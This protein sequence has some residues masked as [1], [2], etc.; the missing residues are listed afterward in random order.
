P[1][2]WGYRLVDRALGSHLAGCGLP[3]IAL[4]IKPTSR[5]RAPAGPRLVV[6]GASPGSSAL[7]PHLTETTA[8]P[9]APHPRHRARDFRSSSLTC[10]LRP[11]AAKAQGPSPDTPGPPI[12]YH[13]GAIVD[14]LADE[15]Q[16][17][18]S[19]RGGS[20]AGT[21]CSSAVLI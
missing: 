10:R 2:Y 18:S 15:V 19:R 3:A 5:A 7:A 8:R 6:P 20:R 9:L 11:S 21:T 1:L 13:S 17:A 12:R 16:I 4:S 14:R